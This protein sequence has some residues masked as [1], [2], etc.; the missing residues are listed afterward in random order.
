[1][2]RVSFKNSMI[3]VLLFNAAF[4]VVNFSYFQAYFQYYLLACFR[5][6]AALHFEEFNM[7]SL[8]D[9]RSCT[10]TGLEEFFRVL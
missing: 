8:Y 2:S 9:I 1:M 4:L 7:T 6:R 5:G 3:I 10:R